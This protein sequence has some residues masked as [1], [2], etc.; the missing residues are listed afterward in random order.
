MGLILNI[1][2]ST[3]NCSISVANQGTCISLVE[4]NIN[5]H[6]EKIYTF[7]KYA[8]EGAK[9][10]FFELNAI[11][12][13]K[14]PGSYTGI[15]IGATV[16]KALCYSLNIPMLSIDSLSILVQRLSILNNNHIIIPII[17]AK[18]AVYTAVFNSHHQMIRPITKII[19]NKNSFQEYYKKQIYIIGNNIKKYKNILKIDFKDFS[20]FYPSSEAMIKISY[21]MFQKK[22][23]ENI[24]SFEPIY[25]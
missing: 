20:I 23:F 9:V 4:E 14:G 16:A 2:T 21:K 17:D 18:T 3:A 5:N 1:E 24:T 8:L 22:Q 11:C 15:R 25:L 12:I 6:D 13:D 10:N 7:I 19:L